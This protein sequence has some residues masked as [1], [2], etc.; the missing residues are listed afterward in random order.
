[1]KDDSTKGLTRR[2][3]LGKAATGALLVAGYSC[4]GLKDLVAQARAAGKLPLHTSSFS[5][6]LPNTPSP[7]YRAMLTEASRDPLAFLESHFT[8][9][10]RQRADAQ[11][12]FRPGSAVALAAQPGPGVSQKVQE[13]SA[14]RQ[15]LQQ[16]QKRLQEE[17]EKLKQEL[18]NARDHNLQVALFGGDCGAGSKLG[19]KYQV[20]PASNATLPGKAPMAKGPGAPPAIAPQPFAGTLRI[21]VSGFAP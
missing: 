7:E 10:E 19:F 9:T 17:V 21:T 16:E 6:L 15:Q 3:A 2:E 8:M 20:V 12:M 13:S 14:Q 1:M 18:Q 4:F 11:R 5:Q